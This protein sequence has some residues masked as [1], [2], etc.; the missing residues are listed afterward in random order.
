MRN[1]PFYIVLLDRTVA[2][3]CPCINLL[4]GPATS[5]EKPFLDLRLLFFLGLLQKHR[6]GIID[7]NE[8]PLAIHSVLVFNLFT[9]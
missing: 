2:T 9:I 7:E 3:D 5:T 1:V 6:I 8:S 4:E